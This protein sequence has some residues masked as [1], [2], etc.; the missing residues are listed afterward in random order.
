MPQNSSSLKAQ[1]V[2]ERVQQVPL[3]SSI[4]VAQVARE[5]VQQE[6]YD[7]LDAAEKWILKVIQ[8]AWRRLKLRNTSQQSEDASQSLVDAF[9]AIMGPKHTG[10]M[11]LYG[12]GVTK[13][14]LNGKGHSEL[15]SSA[16]DETLCAQSPQPAVQPVNQPSAVSNNQGGENKQGN[17]DNIEDLT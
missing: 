6:K 3:D 7:I 1:V 16:T 2:Q 17:D 15:S 14:T 10:Y 4:V 13:S 5:R 9:A 12:R 8:G 11:R